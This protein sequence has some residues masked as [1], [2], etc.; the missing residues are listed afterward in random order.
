MALNFGVTEDS[1]ELL[2]CKEIKP[3]NYKE[4]QS[5]IFTGRCDAK[6]ETT[7]LWPPVAKSWVIRKELYAGED[8]R[9]EEKRMPEDQMVEW[10][11]WLN[12]K[13]REAWCAAVYGVTESDLTEQLNNS[14][15]LVIAT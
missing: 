4:N 14:N 6:V 8:W 1:W 12:M 5:W 9:Q 7:I 2:D 15:I 3:V 11:H 13:D 10:P